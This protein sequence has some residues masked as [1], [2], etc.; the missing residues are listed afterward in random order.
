MIN[1]ADTGIQ[2]MTDAFANTSWTHKFNAFTRL[3]IRGNYVEKIHR[4]GILVRA[5]VS[6]LIE[7]NTT[8][9]IGVSCD[10]NTSVVK[11]LDNIGFV[12]AQ[13]AYYTTGAVFQ[14]N[15]AFNTRVLQGDGQAWDFDIRV[16][17]SIYQY[18]FSHHNEGG[19]L[20]VMDSTNNNIFRYNISQNDYDA[21]G[22]FHLR[23]GGGNLHIYN[24]VIYRDNGITSSLTQSSTSGMANY[25]NNIFYNAAGD[26]FEQQLHEIQP[27]P[28]LRRKLERA[29]RPGQ[30]CRR[31]AVPERRR[32]VRHRHCI[33]VQ[34]GRR[35][36]G[37]QCR[38]RYMGQR[39][40]RLLRQSAV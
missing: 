31:S 27:Q 4:D 12:A 24:N 40:L 33:G 20:L 34:T 19:A 13:W 36:A 7:Y 15:E 21:F 9:E 14:H 22:T 29:E 8:N 2:V 18:N 16:S 5:S 30:G 1:V 37:H 25:T 11:Y 35:L 6:P 32:R 10:V 17:D 28:V 26:V 39:Q 3:I 23:P 38:G